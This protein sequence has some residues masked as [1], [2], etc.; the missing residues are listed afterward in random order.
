MKTLA[1]F[2]LLWVGPLALGQN[3]A[4]GKPAPTKTEPAITQSAAP[5]KT[6]ELASKASVRVDPEKEAAI[7]KLFE[8]QGTRSSMVQVLA[9]MSE[10]MKP[11]LSKM[12]PP[13]EYQDK[14]IPLFF[15]KF[16]GK[17]K[18]GDLMDLMVP[19]Y[20][21]YLTKE[22]VNGLAQFYQTP[23]GKKML[24]VLPQLV[25]ETQT[26]AMNMGQELGR[27]AMMEVLTEH[28]DLQKALED[29]GARKN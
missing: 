20:D 9:G 21:R 25:I 28:P 6:Q 1:A 3:A 8:I 16:Q 15:E 29:A 24:S 13:G 17:M 26:A 12:L 4:T 23:L 10:N 19:I 27:Q 18:T 14:L 22:D 5:T 2:V 11:T 7:R